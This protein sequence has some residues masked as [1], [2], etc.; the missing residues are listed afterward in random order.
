MTEL[1]ANVKKALADE[2]GQEVDLRDRDPEARE[3]Q[4][5]DLQVRPAGPNDGL[6]VYFADQNQFRATPPPRSRRGPPS[7]SGRPSSACPTS[8]TCRSTHKVHESMINK[9]AIGKPA[10]VRV[11]SNSNLL[12][13]KVVKVAP[14]PDQGAGWPPT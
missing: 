14:L 13:G 11:E 4:E 7:A 5:A 9:V 3:A 10:K 8:A 2:A 1:E 12:V 6:L